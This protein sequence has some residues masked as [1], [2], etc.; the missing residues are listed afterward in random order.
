MPK[1]VQS[2]ATSATISFSKVL[3]II[4]TAV[5]LNVSSFWCADIGPL[6][7]A[8]LIRGGQRRIFRV[9]W[10]ENRAVVPQI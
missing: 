4:M 10:A 5:I 6:S 2:Q 8:A 3:H 1:M 7:D 9:V